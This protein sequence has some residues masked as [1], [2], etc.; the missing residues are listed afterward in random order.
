MATLQELMHAYDWEQTPLRQFQ[1]RRDAWPDMDTSS[2]E[3]E[4]LGFTKE[5]LAMYVSPKAGP[6]GGPFVENFCFSY[7]D[8]VANDWFAVF[9]SNADSVGLVSTI[10]PM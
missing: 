9:M 5:G 1:F 2:V 7:E 4:W 10:I 8:L 6:R 3:D